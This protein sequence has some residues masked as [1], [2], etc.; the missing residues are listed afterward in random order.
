MYVSMFKDDL[1]VP[2]WNPLKYV[3]KLRASR[4]TVADASTVLCRVASSG[5]HMGDGRLDSHIEQLSREYA[6]LLQ[7]QQTT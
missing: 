2:S 1:R 3:I 5:G 6:F 7:Q 4:A